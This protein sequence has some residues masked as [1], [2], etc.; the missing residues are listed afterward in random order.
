MAT[1]KMRAFK[2]W[3]N[4][5]GI[6]WSDALELVATESPV[7]IRAVCD[8]HEGDVVAKIPKESCLTIKTCGARQMIEEAELDGYLGLAVAL[9]YER[10]LGPVSPWF[11][12]LQL[13]PHSEP[14][15][16]LWSLSEI[17]SLLA[18]TEL[19]K[20]IKEDKVLIHEDWK[21][22]IQPLLDNASL[23]LNLEGFG[24]EEYF[25]AKSLIA[26]RSFQIDDYH[27]FGMVPLADLF[28]HKTGAEDVHFTSISSDSESDSDADDNNS[29]TE[30]Q[31]NSDHEP[32]S[33]NAHS[34]GDSLSG[35]D[36]DSSSMSGNDPTALEMIMVKN[37]KAGVEVFNTYGSLGNAALLHRYGFTESD[38]PYDILNL[39]LELVL[40][41]SSSRF[42]YRHSRRRLSLWRALDYSGCV[43]QDSEYF[44]ISYYGE[45]QI[46]LIIL[47][48]ILLLSEEAYSEVDLA[49]STMGDVEKSWQLFLSKQGVPLENG[50]ELNKNSL[51][52]ESVCLALL[53]LADARES[54]YGSNYLRNDLKELNRCSQ[55][56]EPKLYHSLVLRISERKIL[57]KL[58]TYASAGATTK[59]G[60]KRKGKRRCMKT[61]VT[62]SV[63]YT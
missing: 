24:I 38:N 10:S 60:T 58:R 62:R 18:G 35:S 31:N 15:P 25:A 14:I 7:F 49:V 4:S 46:E 42:S 37:V 52:T 27:G 51:L 47:L 1:R 50:S 23:G 5:K 2:K 11:G 28:N 26:S 40:Q 9:M 33:E 34:E 12:Y 45:P 53:S 36:L 8:L 39:D 6:E 61:Q 63:L 55:L 30:Y 16:L 20:I 41:W 19:H 48:Y 21:E 54:L 22:C 13:L 17:N 44:E 57:Q 29:N 43:S 3:M 32:I 59:K 56:S